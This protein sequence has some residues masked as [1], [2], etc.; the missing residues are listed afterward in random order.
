MDSDTLKC[1]V[2]R[3][4]DKEVY[5]FDKNG[6]YSH[7]SIVDAKKLKLRD[8][9]F[10]GF[11]GEY[12]KKNPLYGYF[13]SNHSNAMDRAVACLRTG[14]SINQF[15]ENFS[16]FEKL[17]ELDDFEIANTVIRICNRKFYF[18]DENGKYSFLTEKNVLPSNVFIGNIF[19]THKSIS[20]SCDVQLHQFS[21][22]IKVDNLNVLKKALGQMCIGDTVQDL[23]ERCNN[24]T[25]RKLVLPEGVERFVTRIERPTFV[26]IPENPNKVTTF[27][28]IHLYVGLVSE[29]DEDISSYLNAH[30][31]EINKM[32]WNK[33]END[34]RFLKY[35]IPINFLKIAK[36][37]FKKCTSELHYVFELKCI[38]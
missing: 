9:G 33:L 19:V 37:T 8:L 35:G 22:V 25:F 11:T 30:I 31:K 28:Y 36:V 17:Y 3:V 23:I 21:R 10:N 32:V 15:R 14:D 13:S 6:I 26:C 4:I 18:F 29:W 24:V 2:M 16:K 12:Y 38:D 7:T 27:D 34:R 1:S 5:F 20:Y